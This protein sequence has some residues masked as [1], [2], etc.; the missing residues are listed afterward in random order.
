MMRSSPSN[1]FAVPLAPTRVH[2]SSRRNFLGRLAWLVVASGCHSS[3]EGNDAGATIGPLLAPADLAGRMADVAAGKIV[4]LYIGPDMLFAKGHIPGARNI[5]EASSDDGMRALD[6]ALTSAAPDAEIVLYCGC[7]PVKNCP[8]VRPASA[9]LRARGRANARVLD[10]PT[11]FST[12][13][14]DHGYPVARG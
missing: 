12:D 2:P 8:N 10:L 14:S 3:A 11:R 9:A 4:V 7:C 1:P 6:L 5:G 13:W